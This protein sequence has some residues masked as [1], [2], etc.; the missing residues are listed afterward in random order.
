MPFAVF[1]NQRHHLVTDS[2]TGHFNPIV[3]LLDKRHF[4]GMLCEPCS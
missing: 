2:L 1:I 3:L 4:T